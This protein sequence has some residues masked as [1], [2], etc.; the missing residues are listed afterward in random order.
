MPLIAYEDYP[1][2]DELEERFVSAEVILGACRSLG[3]GR[4][5]KKSVRLR[6]SGVAG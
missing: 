2:H 5:T 6:L 1:W 3:S 4:L